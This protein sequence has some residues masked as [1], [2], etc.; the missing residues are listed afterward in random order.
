MAGERVLLDHGGGGRASAEL[1]GRIFLSH[2]GNETLNALEDAAELEPGPGRL[3]LTTDAYVVSPI[4]FPGG[5]IGSLSIHGTVNDLAMRGARP[6][7]LT[8]A[9]IL[10]EGLALDELERVVAS[11]A[12]A[13]EQAGVVVAAGD[14]K[15]VDRGAAD[16]MFITT[17]GVGVIPEGRRVSVHL[18]RPGDAVLVSGGL[19]EHGLAILSARAGLA[20]ESPIVSDSAPLNGLV[21]ELAQ[22]LGPDLHCLRDPTRGGLAAVLNEIAQASGVGVEIEDQALPVEEAVA[23]AC[24]LLGLDPLYLAN[25]GKLVAVVAGPAG[26]R[27][28]AALRGHPLGRKAALIGRVAAERPGRVVALTGGGGRRLVDQPLGQPLPRIC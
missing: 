21:E 28:L 3:A 10:E 8:A 20:F 13:A 19:G 12:R 11:M 6:L 9:F 14:T 24:E 4:F 22:A 25:E 26:D 16:R 2:L 18:A 27:A 5:D 7:A 23:A 15:V 17:A 1:I